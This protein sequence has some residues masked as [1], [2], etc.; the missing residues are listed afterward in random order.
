[1]PNAVRS[2]ARSLRLGKSA[3]GPDPLVAT[4]DLACQ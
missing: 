3:V 2:S 1:M 4:T